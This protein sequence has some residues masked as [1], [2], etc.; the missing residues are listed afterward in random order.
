[1]WFGDMLRFSITNSIMKNRNDNKKY[2]L[3]EYRKK[4]IKRLFNRLEE[5]Q[6]KPRSNLAAVKRMFGDTHN[7]L[8]KI[9][10][11]H[12]EQRLY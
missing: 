9:P 10:K 6:N 8:D 1:M 11:N 3:N 5:I 12:T 7:H 4:E 2:I